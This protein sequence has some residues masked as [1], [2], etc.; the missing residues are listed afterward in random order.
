VAGEVEVT[1]NDPGDVITGIV[2]RKVSEEGWFL[3]AVAGSVDIGEAKQT[4]VF[5]DREI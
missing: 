3:G 2:C 5:V 1:G 4:T